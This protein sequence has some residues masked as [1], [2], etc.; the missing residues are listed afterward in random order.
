MEETSM[1]HAEVETKTKHACCAPDVGKTTVEAARAR[2]VGDRD[3]PSE[4][5]LE[6]FDVSSIAC[7]SCVCIVHATFPTHRPPAFPTASTARR[8][9]RATTSASHVH[10][11]SLLLVR[12]VSFHRDNDVARVWLPSEET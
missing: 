3:R 2:S 5:V 1:G 11:T 8:T 7:V 9:S 6:D 10:E 12:N 4:H